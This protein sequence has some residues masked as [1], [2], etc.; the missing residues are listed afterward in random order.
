VGLEVL[1]KDTGLAMGAL[2]YLECAAALVDIFVLEFQDLGAAKGLV[3]ALYLLLIHE[4]LEGNVGLESSGVLAT[5]WAVSF[6]DAR[7]PENALLA[8]DGEAAVALHD[9]V[10]QLVANGAQ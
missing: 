5:G 8:E 7:E 9:C 6:A 4:S 1:V 2:H 3:P 10:W